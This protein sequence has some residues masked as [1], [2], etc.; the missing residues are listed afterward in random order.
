[1]AV[2]LAAC[3]ELPQPFRSDADIDLPL[4]ATPSTLGIGVIP[5]YGVSDAQSGDLSA[6]IAETL[7]LRDIPAESVD[8]V[9]RLGFSLETTLA[10][11]ETVED[12]VRLTYQWRLLG[13][14]S[15][16]IR[17]SGTEILVVDQNQWQDGSPNGFAFFATAVGEH[18]ANL[19][20]PPI[21]TPAPARSPWEGIT[22]RIEPPLDAP[23]D[24]AMA[25]A[26]GLASRFS[27]AGFEPPSGPADFTVSATVTVT[28]YDS[29]QDDIAIV[30]QVADGT[31]ADLG[32]VRL[33]NRIPSGELDG[34]WGLVA[35]AIIDASLPGILEIIAAGRATG[36]A[37]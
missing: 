14:T 24:G 8:G 27:R 15:R 10:D 33:D 6:H 11:I 4:P 5:V 2:L 32:A 9:G 30:W 18:V 34:P 37:E 25:L 26:Q 20:S 21:L 36:M 29:V 16:D 28:A 1:M 22:V 3:G 35:E 12:F 19:V 23:G 31:G 17:Q 7:R 13:R